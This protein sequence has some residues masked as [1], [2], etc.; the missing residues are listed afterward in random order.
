[1]N[2]EFTL[3]EQN[4]AFAAKNPQGQQKWWRSLSRKHGCGNK[5]PF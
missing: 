4:K 3:V 2:D 1:M 5:Q